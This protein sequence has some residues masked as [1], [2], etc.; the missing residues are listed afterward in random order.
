M[1]AGNNALIGLSKALAVP[2]ALTS[3]RKGHMQVWYCS[4]RLERG[5]MNS[6]NKGK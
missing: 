5:G 1:R 4:L 2:L 3:N 6:E